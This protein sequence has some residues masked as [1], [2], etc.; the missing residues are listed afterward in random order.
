M[1]RQLLRPDSVLCWPFALVCVHLRLLLLGS[2][3]ALQVMVVSFV[4]TQVLNQLQ[5][6]PSLAGIQS[7]PFIRLPPFPHKPLIFMFGGLRMLPVSL[8]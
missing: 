4:V 6:V 8:V 1:S 3:A 5:K 7:S 2:K